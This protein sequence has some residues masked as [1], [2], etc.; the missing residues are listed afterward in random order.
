MTGV[1]RS[2]W[3]KFWSLRSSWAGLAA[4]VV[5]F[6]G[7]GLLA[8]ALLVDVTYDVIVLSL[9]G[10]ALAQLV[11]GTLGV[12]VMT[13][14]YSSGNI[15]STLIA[16]PRRLPVLVAKVVVF[17][18]VSFALMLAAAAVVFT[19]GQAIIGD[20]G[21]SFAD[22]GAVRA[23][24]GTAAYLTGAGLLGLLLGAALRSTAAALSTYAGVMFLLGMVSS[25]VLSQDFR[26]D[27]GKFL[28]S[29]AGEAMTAV[30]RAPESLSPGQGA[31]VFAGYLLLIG[32]LGAWRLLT[33]DA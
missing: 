10:S 19:A 9:S 1:L 12:L 24:F 21:A 28:P 29:A 2:E 15:R 27:V 33:R 26:D 14:E 31:L 18:V 30:V 11:V 16:V 20:A 23:V 5:V 6:V 22:P 17:G 4:A 3:I 25:L 8:S 32:A 13:G 7:T